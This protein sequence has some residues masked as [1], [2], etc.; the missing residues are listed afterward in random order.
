M[1]V[2]QEVDR[3][4]GLKPVPTESVVGSLHKTHIASYHCEWMLGGDRKGSLA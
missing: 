1:T 4:G 2:A 3:D